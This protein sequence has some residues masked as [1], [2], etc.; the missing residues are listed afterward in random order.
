M[1]LSKIS[2]AIIAL[3]VGM[4]GTASAADDRYVIQVDNSKK[5]VV[6]ALAK[7]LGG[8][9]HIDGEGFFS[10]SFSGKDLAQVKGLLNNPH[11][12]LVEEDQRRHLMAQYNDDSGNPMT[13]Q[14]T[15]YAVYQSQADQLSFN[16]AAGTKVCVIDSGLDRSNPDFEW[17]N[18]S[19]DNDSGTGNWDENGG[20]HGTHVAGT[21]GAADNNLGVIGMAPGVDMHIIK[22]F[23]ADGW[24][25]SSDLAHAA[26]LCSQAGAN[27]ISMS[28]GGGGSNST[29]SNAFKA[30]SEAG[31]LVVAAAGN[32]GNN[33]RSYPAG[34]PSVMMVGANDADN[35]IADFSQF[36]TC[37]TGKGRRA[38]TDKKTCVEVT[39]GGVDTLSTYPAGMATSAN[40]TANDVAYASSAMENS[41]NASGN[42][43]YMGT[44]EATDGGANGNICVIDRG[45][46]S[47]HDKVANC[48]ASGGI[49]AVIINNEAGML[50]GTLG[51]TNTT[52]I[53]AVGAAFEDRSALVAASSMSIDIGTSDYGLMSG[54]SMATPAVS[55]VA[56]LVWSNHS[57]CTGEQIRDALKATAQD[58]G[59]SG[60]D[61]YFGDG[62]VK[63]AAADAY[64]TQQGC[65]GGVTPPPTGDITLTASTGTS[66]GKPVV[67]LTFDGAATSNVDIYRNGSLLV[68]TTND[69]SYRDSFG[70]RDSGTYTYK[71]CDEG[72]S[73]C[74]VDVTV[75]F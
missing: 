56:A 12:K 36:P 44:A 73:N 58:G 46:I 4:L 11:V 72:S 52:T 1:K 3:T 43:Y 23:N 63:A 39:A 29:E 55:G 16:A 6:K 38:V 5:G 21:I 65:G 48:E 67:N 22:V 41:G 15:P 68:T 71:V 37:T 26:N 2:S 31:G 28:L 35:N 14:I 8:Q 10:A 49:G 24:G 30:F 75:T 7:K 64:L 66:K 51:D 33:V 74:S 60:H 32:D 18:I 62:I 53:P 47:F 13:Q 9:I 45:V 70:K 69:G 40:M 42:S 17:N 50:Y 61:V 54:T 59:A 20:P 34:Y 27:I 19:G 25:Y 57:G